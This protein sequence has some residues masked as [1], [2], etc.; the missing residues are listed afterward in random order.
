[1]AEVALS[2]K[3][4]VVTGVTGQVAEPLALGL[5]K[6]NEVVGAARFSDPQARRRLEEGGVRCVPVNLVRGEVGEL[7]ADADYV[8]HMAVAKSNRWGVDLDANCGGLAALMEHHREAAAFLHCSTA[9]VYRPDGHRALVEDDELGDNHGVWPF[10]RTYSITKIAA[11]AVAR[12]AARRFE[13]PTTIARLSVPYGDN[14]GWPAL[15]LEMLLGGQPIEVHVDAPSVFSPIHEADIAATLPG[16]L[17]AAAVP[18]TVV[19]WG[20]PALSIEEWCAYLGDLV[21]E[22]PRF[23]PTEATIESTTLDLTRL[24]GLVGPTRVDWR[25]GMAAMVA[26]RHPEAVRR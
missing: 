6:D 19:N 14:G 9:A 5:A 1:M 4:I 20:G 13:L 26:H 22:P 11:E 18:A 12:Y 7:P 17:G 15:H 24:H 25:E 10:L 3:T 21:G 8:I 23:Q 16:L 2:G